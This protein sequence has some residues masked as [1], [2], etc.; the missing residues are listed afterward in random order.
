MRRSATG[1]RR[2]RQA[3][4][5]ARS[6]GAGSKRA[7]YRRL[8]AEPAGR[9][10]ESAEKEHAHRRDVMPSRLLLLHRRVCHSNTRIKIEHLR[11]EADLIHPSQPGGGGRRGDGVSRRPERRRR[12]EVQGEATWRRT[13]QGGARR[14]VPRE[15]GEAGGVSRCKARDMAASMWFT[16]RACMGAAAVAKVDA[17]SSEADS[18]I[19]WVS[20]SPD[21]NRR[22]SFQGPHA[23]SPTSSPRQTPPHLRPCHRRGP[24]CGR[25]SSP[26]QTLEEE[27]KSRSLSAFLAAAC[28]RR[29]GEERGGWGF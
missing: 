5:E 20:A 26:P 29:D 18:A 21:S 11:G 6:Q 1:R 4:G 9:N 8:A 16:R 10:R 13:R 27:E 2:E 17:D 15:A 23:T 25:L 3:P 14:G 7:R 24:G 28:F 22:R 12:V 19:S